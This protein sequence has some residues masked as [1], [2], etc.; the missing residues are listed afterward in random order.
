MGCIDNSGTKLV[1]YMTNIEKIK[2]DALQISIFS[3]DLDSELSSDPDL[4]YEEFHIP[5]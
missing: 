1:F 4:V 2:D 3:A 5:E